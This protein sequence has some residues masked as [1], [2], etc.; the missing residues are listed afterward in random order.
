MSIN[1]VICI[2]NLTRDAE[3]RTVGQ[4]Q[5]AKV[6][7][8]M[9]EKFRKQDGTIGENTEFIDIEVWGQAGVYPYLL[10]GQMVYVEGSIKTQKWTGQDGAQHQQ[11]F[12]KAASI[13]LLGQ[14]PQ[15]QQPAAAPRAAAPTPPAPQYPSAPPQGYAP[16]PQAPA[17][18]A[19]P[20]YPPQ[21]AAPAPAPQYPAPPAPPAPQPQGA[22]A[23]APTDDIPF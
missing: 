1:K 14:R 21:T 6:G 19:Y 15:A 5:V 9:T 3:V 11:T 17:P 8:A 18:P 20:Q 10:K 13:Q 2:G 23:A 7:L 16:Q 4:N 22:T 12:I